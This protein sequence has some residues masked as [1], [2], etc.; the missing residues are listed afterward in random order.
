MKSNLL[1]LTLAGGLMACASIVND[2]HV[3]ITLSF[4]DNSAGTCDLKNKRE[5]YQV[6]MP[7]TVSVRR[8]D[9]A[10]VF[11]CF[12]A[13]GREARGSIPSEIGDTI[14]GNIIF[15]GGI[16]ALIDAENDK[17]RTYPEAFVIPVVKASQS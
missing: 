12:T 17:H 5:E 11:T 4:S 7:S 16:G 13:D 3:P 9:D 2:S 14:A 15:G 1:Y 8:S 6:T 10:L